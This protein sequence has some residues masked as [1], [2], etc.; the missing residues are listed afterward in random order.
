MLNLKKFIE[1]PMKSVLARILASDEKE[2]SL[3]D[4]SKREKAELSIMFEKGYIVFTK[5]EF[6]GSIPFVFSC[7]EKKFS[8]GL[9]KDSKITITDL[10]N[11]LFEY[12]II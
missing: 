10:G 8:V 11:I 9:K 1:H 7:D 2:I 5:L 12:G 6:G 3:G 4:L